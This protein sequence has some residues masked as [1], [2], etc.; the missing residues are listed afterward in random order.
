MI[1][2]INILNEIEIKDPTTGVLYVKDDEE[3]E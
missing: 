3:D 1:K 2:L